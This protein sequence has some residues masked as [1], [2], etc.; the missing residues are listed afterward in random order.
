[1]MAIMTLKNM[2]NRVVVTGMGVVSPNATGL[3]NFKTAIKEGKSGIKFIPEL[4]EL[5]FGCRIGGAPENVE[6]ILKNVFKRKKLPYLSDSVGYAVTAA[7]E[8]WRNAGLKY[9][10]EDNPT[11]WDTGAIIGSGVCDLK[12]FTNHVAS[13]IDAGKVRRISVSAKAIRM[14]LVLK[15]VKRNYKVAEKA[16]E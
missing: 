14:G 7:I 9:P 16:A 5:K 2:K 10:V 1:M 6:E 12:T 15:P 13:K 8:A 11:D 3:D 4:E